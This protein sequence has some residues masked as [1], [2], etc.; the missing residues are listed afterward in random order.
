[1]IS[2]AT[3]RF[4]FLALP[5]LIASCGS[6]HTVVP[7]GAQDSATAKQ[8]FA[9]P[10]AVSNGPKAV[11]PEVHF[12]FGEVISGVVIEHSFVLNN[13]GSAPMLIQKVSMTT[14]LLVTQ[15][16]HEVAPGAEGRIHFKL[17]TAN[18]EGEFEGAIL[19]FLNDPALPQASLTFSGRVV[20]A[21][22]LSPMPAFFVAGQRGRGN[23]AAIE[24]VNHE[25]EPLRI[26]KVE[27]PTE[28]YTTELQTLK[29]GQRYRLTLTLN[30]NGPGG[31]T[32]DTM[33]IRTSSK[34][35]PVLNVDANTYLYERV[36]TF[37]DVVDFGTWRAAEAGGAAMTLMIHQEGGSGFRVQLSSDVPG[38]SLKSER[39]PKGD[40]YQVEITLVSEKVRIGPMK[41]SIVIDTNDREFPKVVVPVSGQIVER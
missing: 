38:L 26:E 39:G 15:M 34:R 16:P 29:R 3:R 4:V 12:A 20:P 14:P 23:R 1:V 8:A 32:T 30:P 13:L 33:R 11:F 31:K 37:P 9:S 22:Q 35:M 7:S 41:G 25:P 6:S 28:R 19:V 24:I 27:H 5:P 36:H 10:G 18:L 17:E 2:R 21:I 40:R